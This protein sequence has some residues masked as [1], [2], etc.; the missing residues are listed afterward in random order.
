LPL[1]FVSGSPSLLSPAVC[2]WQEVLSSNFGRSNY[3][4]G[5]NFLFYLGFGFSSS[6]EVGKEEGWIW[7]IYNGTDKD[8]DGDD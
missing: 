5:L 3:K 4:L 8:D 1:S 7:Y 6:T 2:R